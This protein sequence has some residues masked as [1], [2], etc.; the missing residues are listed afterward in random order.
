LAIIL[1]FINYILFQWAPG[2]A[3]TDDIRSFALFHKVQGNELMHCWFDFYLT[4]AYAI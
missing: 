4:T 3:L 1:I 2:M